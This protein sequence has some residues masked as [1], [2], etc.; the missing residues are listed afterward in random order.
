MKCSTVTTFSAL[1][2]FDV[3]LAVS[4]WKDQA[5]ITLR[6]TEPGN[7]IICEGIKNSALRDAVV[8]FVRSQESHKN[9]PEVRRFLQ[10]LSE[11][12]TEAL[13]ESDS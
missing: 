1:A 3:E 12:L 11:G 13:K 7:K 9:K 5:A 6:E 8:L 10:E 4:P 2:S